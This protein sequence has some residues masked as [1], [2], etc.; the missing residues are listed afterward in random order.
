MRNPCV[1]EMLHRKIKVGEGWNQI[2][3]GNSGLNIVK[4]S[5]LSAGFLSPLHHKS[6]ST[7]P[8]FPSQ[9]SSLTEQNQWSPFEGSTRRQP[10]RLHLTLMPTE[11]TLWAWLKPPELR[12]QAK[13]T[14][15]QPSHHMWLSAIQQGLQWAPQEGDRRVYFKMWLCFPRCHRR[16]YPHLYLWQSGHLISVSKALNLHQEHGTGHTIFFF[17]FFYFSNLLDSGAPVFENPCMWAC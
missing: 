6:A 16:G 9:A 10:S 15:R 7:V 4:Q 11:P 14:G 3:Q 17:L 8:A 5:S 13:S 1:C 12:V 2:I